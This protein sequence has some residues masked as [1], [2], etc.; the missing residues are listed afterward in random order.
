MHRILQPAGWA[1]PKGYANGVLAEGRTIHLAGQIGWTAEA[2]FSSDDLVE[3]IRQALDNVVAL[4]REAEA[5]P[6]HIVSMVWYLIDRGEY[7]ARQKEIGAAYRAVIG[8]HYPAMTA[9]IV[10]GL[11]E[12]RAK[13]EIQVTAVV[14]APFIETG[15]SSR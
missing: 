5:G 10:A 8:R 4:L 2:R 14:P 15:G 6:E 7:L 13:V 3:Q 11:I 9:V 1:P 12:A